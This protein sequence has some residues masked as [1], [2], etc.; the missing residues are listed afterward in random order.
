MKIALESFIKQELNAEVQVK[1]VTKK[2][3]I[4]LES[5]QRKQTIM[6]REKKLKTRRGKVFINNEL[7]KNELEIQKKIY[8]LADEE[9]KK[10]KRVRIC[11]N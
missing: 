5:L 7:P 8:Q 4:E 6:D 1:D 10:R 9:K 11:Y 3:Q 2:C